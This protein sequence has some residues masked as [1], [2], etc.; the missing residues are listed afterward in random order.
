MS[1]IDLGKLASI[2]FATLLAFMTSLSPPCISGKDES[3][4]LC[5]VWLSQALLLPQ[6]LHIFHSNL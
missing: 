2:Y 4:G 1:F 5:L 6:I 3:R